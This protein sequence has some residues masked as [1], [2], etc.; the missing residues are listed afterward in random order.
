MLDSMDSME[1]LDY[2]IIHLFIKLSTL[3]VDPFLPE[4][5]SPACI[6]LQI[7]TASDYEKSVQRY[8]DFVSFYRED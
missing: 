5:S 8:N 3:V 1:S 2:S 6:L 4:V 7:L